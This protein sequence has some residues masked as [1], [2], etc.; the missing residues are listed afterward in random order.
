MKGSFQAEVIRKVITVE[1]V[2]HPFG[3]VTCTQAYIPF[4]GKAVVSLVMF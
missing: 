3:G 4:P 2:E 1:G